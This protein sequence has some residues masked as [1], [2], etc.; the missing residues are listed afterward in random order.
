MPD[1]IDRSTGPAPRRPARAT[2]RWSIDPATRISYAELDATTRDLAAAF[3]EAG[4]TQGH[5]RR[6]DHAQRCALGADRGRAHPDRRRAGAAEHPAGRP[7]TGRATAGRLRAATWSPSRSS[8]GTATS[9]TCSRAA[10][11]TDLPALREVWTAD[12]LPHATAARD[13]DR[14]RA[15]RHRHARR[16][17]GRSCSP[18]EAAAHRRA[19]ST[20]T[21]T[22]WARCGPASRRGASTPTPGCTCRCRSSGWAASAAA[23]CRRC[24]PARRWS[25]RQIPQP[26]THA[27]AAG[28]RA[29]DPVS[30]LARPGR[31]AG[32]PVATRSAPTCRRCGPA[33][34]RRCC[35]PTSAPRPARGPSCSG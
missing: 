27:A 3:V 23:C 10:S 6:A 28:A 32:P 16:H 25:P 18:R 22:R 33:A 11:P 24:W 19:S 35:R 26:E 8:A 17:P 7:G 31:S 5:P 1:T 21:A 34:W 9:T 15:G 13:A 12:Q 4:V 2:S 30:R 29:G 14:R 20:R